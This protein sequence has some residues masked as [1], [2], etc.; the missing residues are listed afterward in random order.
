[1]TP[2]VT[3]NPLLQRLTSYLLDAGE[4]VNYSNQRLAEH[5]RRVVDTR[6]V[7][8]SRRVQTLAGEIK[9]IV[10]QMETGGAVMSRQRAD[11]H[12]LEADPLINLPLERPLFDPP[13]QI[14]TSERPRPAS[15]LLDTEALVALYDLFYIDDTVLRQNIDRLLMSRAEVTLAELVTSYP[16]GQGIAEV[17]VYLQIA[18][19]DARHS[20]NR[21]MQDTITIATRDGV[22]K[23]ISIPRIVYRR[24]V[25]ESVE[26]SPN[27]K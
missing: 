15:A 12:H 24:D 9:H 11:F 14:K 5:L 2:F 19:R 16:V 3:G 21:A 23:T 6:N 18:A 8:E 25:P 10:S 20:I 17:I 22:E 7:I 1:L 26:M 13:E 27:G 4:R